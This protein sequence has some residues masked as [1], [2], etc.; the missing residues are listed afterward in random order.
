MY[1]PPNPNSQP[2]RQKRKY[3]VTQH[4][5]R[6]LDSIE[7]YLLELNFSSHISDNLYAPYSIY[8]SRHS[9]LGNVNIGGDSRRQLRRDASMWG[10]YDHMAGE[11]VVGH[12]LT[13]AAEGRSPTRVADV[14]PRYPTH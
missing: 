11:L 13:A 3:T 7:Q 14:Q 12:S 1:V 9:H 4:R 8:T 5:H 2:C 10:A 6:K